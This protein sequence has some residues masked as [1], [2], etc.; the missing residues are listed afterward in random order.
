[1]RSTIPRTLPAYRDGNGTAHRWTEQ[2]LEGLRLAIAQKEANRT[3]RNR[4]NPK[5]R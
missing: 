2:D 5:R 4:K 3:N 1:M